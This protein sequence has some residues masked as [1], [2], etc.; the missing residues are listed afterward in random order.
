MI[1]LPQQPNVAIEQIITSPFASKPVFACHYDFLKDYMATSSRT[2]V[3]NKVSLISM[4]DDNWD[5]FGAVKPCNEVISNTYK[6]L[7]AFCEY[8]YCLQTDEDVYPT[9]YGSIVLDYKSYAG[10]LSVEIGKT[11]LGFF[12]DFVNGDNM[13][14][15]GI[16]TSFREVPEQL[17]KALACL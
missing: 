3:K 16:D 5:G 9:P 7:D 8:G 4:L 17:K 1:A 10:L 15:A 13:C 11:K 12:T 2:A 14:S 6:A